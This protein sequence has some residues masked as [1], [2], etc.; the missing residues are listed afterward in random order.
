MYRIRLCVYGQQNHYL[1]RTHTHIYSQVS[2]YYAFVYVSVRVDGWMKMHSY[3]WVRNEREWDSYSA[4]FW[5]VSMFYTI[6]ILMICTYVGSTVSEKIIPP[7]IYTHIYVILLLML[8]FGTTAVRAYRHIELAIWQYL[9][10][11]RLS[12]NTIQI[13]SSFS[14]NNKFCANKFEEH[15][16]FWLPRFRI[17]IGNHGRSH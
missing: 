7:Y 16:I 17:L 13:D 3:V 5:I 1:H 14:S 4:N 12:V 9:H 15:S 10:Q 11:C 6:I 8:W 2:K